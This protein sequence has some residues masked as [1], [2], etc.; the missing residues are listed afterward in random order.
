MKLIGKLKKQVEDANNKEEA[1][2]IIAKAGM[3]LTTDELEVVTGGTG[4]PK[5][6]GCDADGQPYIDHTGW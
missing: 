5:V 6:Y 3:E 2:N 4:I 1:K